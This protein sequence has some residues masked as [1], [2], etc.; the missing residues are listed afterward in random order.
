MIRGA[1]T[2]FTTLKQDERLIIFWDNQKIYKQENN[3]LQ[4]GNESELVSSM[5]AGV[6]SNYQGFIKDIKIYIPRYFLLL[7]E[8]FRFTYK[9]SIS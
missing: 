6:G 9:S 7:S 1:W 4:W 5:Y 8:L 3:C 2:E